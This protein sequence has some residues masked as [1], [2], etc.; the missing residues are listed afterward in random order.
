[1]ATETNISNLKIHILTRAQYNELA[2]SG[3]LNENELYS[4]NDDIVNVPV[5]DVTVGGISV[6]VGK[7]A[8]IPAIPTITAITNAEIDTIMAS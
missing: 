1:M 6:V 5:E 7:V 8:V 3:G 4:V 2:N